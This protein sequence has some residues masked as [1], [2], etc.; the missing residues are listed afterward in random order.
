MLRD[1]FARVPYD[2]VS[3]AYLEIKASNTSLMFFLAELGLIQLD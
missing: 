3:P 1:L 2:H